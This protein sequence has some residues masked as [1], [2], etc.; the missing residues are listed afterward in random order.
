MKFLN[1]KT[2]KSHLKTT[3]SI[4]YTREDLAIPELVWH[5]TVKQI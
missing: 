5:N 3:S 4:I 2:K 1:L